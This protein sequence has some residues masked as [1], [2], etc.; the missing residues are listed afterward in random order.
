VIGRISIGV[1]V[2]SDFM[3]FDKHL[4]I[5]VRR[6]ESVLGE[7]ID[8]KKVWLNEEYFEEFKDWDNAFLI[9]KTECA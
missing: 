4:N 2:M 6:L 1:Q 9:V 5:V 7:N 3:Q 8:R